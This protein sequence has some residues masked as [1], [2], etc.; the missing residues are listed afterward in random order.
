MTVKIFIGHQ[1]SVKKAIKSKCFSD[2]SQV[3]FFS[4]PSKKNPDAMKINNF[5]LSIKKCKFMLLCPDSNC[6]ESEKKYSYIN[7]TLV[8]KAAARFLL[9][10]S[11]IRTNLQQGWIWEDQVKRPIQLGDLVTVM[12]SLLQY[13]FWVTQRLLGSLLSSVK[14]SQKS[15][16]YGFHQ[17]VIN[18]LMSPR[19]C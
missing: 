16:C 2:Y 4:F 7:Q 17:I 18:G 5:F 19:K 3:D 14:M 11:K 8:C 9:W 12:E 1:W 13:F 6:T 15:Y 10:L